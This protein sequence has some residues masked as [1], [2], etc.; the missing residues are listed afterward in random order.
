MSGPK[1][2]H[3]CQTTERDLLMFIKEIALIARESPESDISM[4]LNWILKFINGVIRRIRE[5]Q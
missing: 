1:H 3:R 2:C 4:D 5:D